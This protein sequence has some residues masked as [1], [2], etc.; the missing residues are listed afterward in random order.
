MS[1]DKTKK[2]KEEQVWPL[3][4]ALKRSIEGTPVGQGFKGGEVHG[5]IG[6]GA[7]MK[8]NPIFLDTEGSS[9]A[10]IQ[11]MM[12]A[13][14]MKNTPEIVILSKVDE[15]EV[16]EAFKNCI[17]DL[18]EELRKKKLVIIDSC[19]ETT[20]SRLDEISKEDLIQSVTEELPK[21]KEIRT[22]PWRRKN[23]KKQFY[24]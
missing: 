2:D 23:K 8:P 1:E 17:E 5:I 16:L 7:S 6:M 15:K 24:K 21:V 9:T 19:I 11:Q 12:S 3:M 18:P 10:V 4:D 14:M 22:E 20:E 13:V